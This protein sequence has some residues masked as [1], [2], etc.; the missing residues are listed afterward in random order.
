MDGGLDDEV[1]EVLGGV[2]SLDG[3]Q[4][5]ALRVALMDRLAII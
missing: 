1:W 4:V 3:E 5:K 2:S